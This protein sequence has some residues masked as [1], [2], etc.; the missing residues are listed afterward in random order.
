MFHILLLRIGLKNVVIGDNLVIKST[1][2]KD[3]E[4]NGLDKL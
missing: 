2:L 1:T 3:L 4:I